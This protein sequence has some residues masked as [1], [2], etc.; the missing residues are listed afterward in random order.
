MALSD[1]SDSTLLSTYRAG[2]A[3]NATPAQKRGGGAAALEL[4]ER[5]R[6]LAFAIR[7]RVTPS[8][9]DEAV[10]EALFDAVVIKSRNERVFRID[11]DAEYA[12]W[13]HRVIT[14]TLVSALRKE[15]YRLRN[16]TSLTVTT[17]EGDEVERP[18]VATNDADDLLT[19]DM[20]RIDRK[21]V[22]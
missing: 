18:D 11:G 12:T 22:V 7:N 13:L 20:I 21:S 6:K 8:L 17:Q 2:L 1:F 4:V 9:K 19:D 10:D 5:H 14:N 15:T 3:L 16:E